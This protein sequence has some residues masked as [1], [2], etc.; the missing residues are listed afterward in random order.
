MWTQGR[1]AKQLNANPIPRVVGKWPG[2]LDVVLRMVKLFETGYVFQGFSELF[3]EYQCTTLN[4]RIFWT[5][6]VGSSHSSKLAYLYSC[7]GHYDG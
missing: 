6:Q 2:N 4:T 7:S 3:A 1:A 5:D